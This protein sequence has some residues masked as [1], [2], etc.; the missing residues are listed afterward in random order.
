VAAVNGDADNLTDAEHRAIASEIYSR[1][2]AGESKSSLE[3]EYWDDPG[4]H[5]KRFTAYIRRWLGRE[6]E[7]KSLQSEHIERLE[8]LLRAHG[9]S[10]TDAG[11]LD[12]E[13]RLLAKSRESALAA[14]RVYNDPVAGFRTETFIV[15][16]VI[17]W[18]SLFQAVLERAGVDYYERDAN[19]RQV[20]VDGR[21]R[22]KDTWALVN[23]ALGDPERAAM[24]ANLDFFLKLRHLIAH[25]YLPALDPQVVGESQ[26]MLLNYESF[27]VEQFGPESGLAERLSVP[28]QLSGFRN[29]AGLSAL[30]RAQA[31]LP[32]DVQTFLAQHRKEVSDEVLRSPEYALQIFFVPVTANRD[33]SADAVVHFVRP[34]DVTDDLEEKLQDLAVVS[35][36]RRVAVA[37]DDLLRP[38][39]VVNLVRERLP[40]RF[41]SDTHQRAWKHYGVRPA[42][43]SAE[44]EATDDRYCRYDRLMRGYGYTRAWVDRLVDELSDAARYAE[45]VGFFPEAQ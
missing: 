17:A 25:R 37:S 21:P 27:V 20:L 5:G 19:G 45:I 11:D 44:P 9:V 4:S 39:E 43:G 6:T 7:K 18:N 41:T 16:M 29:S 3:L 30:K 35:K 31:N 40:Y 23:L 2:E 34:G 22:V 28:L 33:R 24:R 12:E 38:S 32:V 1:W 15:L 26:A 42:T 13:F 14:V 36:P 10:P 8:A